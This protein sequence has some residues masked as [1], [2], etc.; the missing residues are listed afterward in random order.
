MVLLTWGYGATDLGL[1]CYVAGVFYSVSGVSP[2]GRGLRKYEGPVT[3]RNEHPGEEKGGPVTLRSEHPGEEPGCSMYRCIVATRYHGT[4]RAYGATR[5]HGTGRSY[6]DTRYHG[7]DRSYGDTRYHGTDLVTLSA[8]AV[9]ADATTSDVVTSQVTVPHLY[10]ATVC[11]Y[12]M[13]VAYGVPRLH[14][15]ADVCYYFMLL[16]YAATEIAYGD[17]RSFMLLLYAATEIAYAGWNQEY[18]IHT[19]AAYRH[20]RPRSTG[21]NPGAIIVLLHCEIKYKKS[22]TRNHFPGTICTAKVVSCI[23]FR[24]IVPCPV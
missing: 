1:W 8:M 15:A 2:E 12:R 17:I 9:G 24:G 11:C 20:Q 14:T 7:T 10:A 19:A 4:D 6:G 21:R 3:L 23:L 13:L 5:Y 22:K 18:V 16:L